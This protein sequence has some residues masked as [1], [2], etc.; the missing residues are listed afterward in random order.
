MGSMTDHDVL[1]H[2]Q[3]SVRLFRNGHY[4]AQTSIQRCCLCKVK[5]L[6]GDSHSLTKHCNVSTIGPA[7][8]P[9]LLPQFA[10]FAF[11]SEE[12]GH[13]LPQMKIRFTQQS[14]PYNQF[15][16]NTQETR[17]KQTHHPTIPW[18]R[19]GTCKSS[20]FSPCPTSRNP[21]CRYRSC[22]RSRTL[23]KR[24]NP[25]QDNW[26]KR[27]RCQ[28]IDL[29]GTLT[30]TYDTRPGIVATRLTDTRRRLKSNF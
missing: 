28:T 1:Q 16:E 10:Q 2:Q 26:I 8:V 27:Q 30:I 20:D 23:R 29:L 11:D 13:R 17:T 4:K 3:S 7:H 15:T 22:I 19:A 18:P 5:I 24:A 9:F 6:T 12:S 21:C 14:L 25:K